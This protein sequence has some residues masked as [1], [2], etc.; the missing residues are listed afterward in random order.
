SAAMT[1][2]TEARR[3]VAITGAPLSALTPSM[4]AHSPS[5]WMWAPSRTSSC[6]CMKRFSKM[7][8]VMREIPFARVINAISWACRSVGKPGNGRGRPRDGAGAG[9]VALDAPAGIGRGDL[10]ARA[11]EHVERRLQ[12]F[13][14]G[15]L[16]KH[17]A[18]GHRGCHGI[19]AGLD[20][21]GQHAVVGPA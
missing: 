12:Q 3:S 5:S 17:V 1:R 14:A 19:G 9:A 18:A 10:D 11:H 20:A 16:Q 8:S 13:A 2:E 4:V 15:I 6:T 7:V 21:V